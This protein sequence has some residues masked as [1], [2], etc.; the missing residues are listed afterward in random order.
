MIGWKE[1]EQ[2]TDLST[3]HLKLSVAYIKARYNLYWYGL[4]PAL[5]I[6][7]TLVDPSI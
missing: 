7:H 1:Q 4:K 6:S 2:E 3:K 5:S